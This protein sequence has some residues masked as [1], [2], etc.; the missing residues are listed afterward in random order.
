MAGPVD[1]A[2]SVSANNWC[3]SCRVSIMTNSTELVQYAGAAPGLID[4]VMQ[5]N[6]MAQP[7][8]GTPLDQEFVE[9]SLGGAGFVWISQ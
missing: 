3:S 7:V 4:A 2:V 5:I 1:G 9:F 8:T 6:F